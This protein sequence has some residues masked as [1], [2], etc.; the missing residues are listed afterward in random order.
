VTEKRRLP[1]GSTDS[2]KTPQGIAL[3]LFAFV[4]FFVAAM[5]GSQIGPWLM[6][7][8]IGI[9][10]FVI[11]LTPALRLNRPVRMLCLGILAALV[12]DLCIRGIP[13]FLL[14]PASGPILE[15]VSSALLGGLAV[16]L[17]NGLGSIAS[18]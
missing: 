9:I 13:L 3:V 14:R 4:W 8:G 2:T 6:P 15:V 7:A 16:I 10:A 11:R 17:G 12:V 18:K 5:I 1:I